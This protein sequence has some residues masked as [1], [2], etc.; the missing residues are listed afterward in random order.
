MP[1]T[2]VKLVGISMNQRLVA[3]TTA[4]ELRAKFV[5]QNGGPP[6]VYVPKTA[7]TV[8]VASP[9]AL[10]RRRSKSAQEPKQIT[11]S[12]RPT[13]PSPLADAALIEVDFRA[14]ANK[15]QQLYPPQSAQGSSRFHWLRKDCKECAMQVATTC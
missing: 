11:R 3:A 12:S 9:L 2:P 8:T 1:Q 14:N 4:T 15:K 7:R 6:R 5:N 13:L 10:A